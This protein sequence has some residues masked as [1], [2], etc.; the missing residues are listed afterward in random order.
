MAATNVIPLRPTMASVQADARR[1][2]RE[3]CA[4]DAKFRLYVLQQQRIALQMALDE[5]DR[6]I[7][8]AHLFA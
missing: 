6:Q 8:A 3:H 5:I 4:R 7:E 2:L 1:V